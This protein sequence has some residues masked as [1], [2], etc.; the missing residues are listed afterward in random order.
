M[1]Q[2]LFPRGTFFKGEN[3]LFSVFDIVFDGQKVH[4]KTGNILDPKGVE[5]ANHFLRR[6]D[7]GHKSLE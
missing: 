3:N 4:V 5:I 1:E 6:S 2:I 7:V